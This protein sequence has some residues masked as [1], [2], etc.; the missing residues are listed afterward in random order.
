MLK[1]LDNQR[2]REAVFIG[3]DTDTLANGAL[4]VRV[5]LMCLN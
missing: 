3:E 4:I 1:D 2:W 5:M